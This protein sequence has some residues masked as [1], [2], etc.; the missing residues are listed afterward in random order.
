MTDTY[1]VCPTSPPIVVM[2]GVVV[3]GKKKSTDLSKYH[4][5]R[6][7]ARSKNVHLIPK[8]KPLFG[9]DPA[10]CS[11]RPLMLGWAPHNEKVGPNVSLCGVCNRLA[12]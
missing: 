6:V 5:V 9:V 8:D 3:P 4:K 10:L 11:V 7:A 12:A 2:Q 1:K